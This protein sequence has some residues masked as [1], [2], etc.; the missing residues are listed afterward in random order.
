MPD[1]SQIEVARSESDACRAAALRMGGSLQRQLE[2]LRTF[3]AEYKG[4]TH[5]E[6]SVRVDL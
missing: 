6:V 4:K 1:G 2:E 5:S 3:R